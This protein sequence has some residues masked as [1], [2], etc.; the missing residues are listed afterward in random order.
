M[1]TIKLRRGLAERWAFVNPILAEGEP[2]FESD[3]GLVKIGDGNTAW[4]D[5]GYLCCNDRVV[6]SMAGVNSGSGLT[7]VELEMDG[8]SIEDVG[9]AVPFDMETDTIT[10]SWKS[11][12]VP[13][14]DW[15]L[16]LERRAAGTSSWIPEGT[17]DFATS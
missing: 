6:Y 14:G 17:F 11:D 5:L 1:T 4:N 15:T 2:G 16:Q 10:V 7:S 3:T 13:A 9:V 12:N 8:L